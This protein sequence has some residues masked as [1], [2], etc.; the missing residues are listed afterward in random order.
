MDQGL[1]HLRHRRY[2]PKR[3]QP[4]RAVQAELWAATWCKRAEPRPEPRVG[5]CQEGIAEV[6][7]L[8]LPFELDSPGHCGQ[9]VPLDP[10]GTMYWV[11]GGALISN[12]NIMLLQIPPCKYQR[13][14]ECSVRTLKVCVYVSL[15]GRGRSNLF[16]KQVGYMLIQE[17]HSK[18]KE[19][20][21]DHKVLP[22][23]KGIFVVL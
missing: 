16:K 21:K 5:M 10:T 3:V 18:T 2:E 7:N 23:L 13:P 6:F 19:A 8:K 12:L 20:T 17:Q 14:F 11:E 1:C 15:L 9:K 4:E 22:F